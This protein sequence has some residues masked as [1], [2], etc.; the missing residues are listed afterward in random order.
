M[1]FSLGDALPLDQVDSTAL[2]AYGLRKLR[3]TYS[4]IWI[5]KTTYYLFWS[6][7][8]NYK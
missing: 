3:T 2:V 5:K 4:C 7:S 8:K 1:I 6:M